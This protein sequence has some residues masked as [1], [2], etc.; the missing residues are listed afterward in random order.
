MLT[1]LK[2]RWLKWQIAILRLVQQRKH[3]REHQTSSTNY[4]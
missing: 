2:I 1:A 4:L 3:N